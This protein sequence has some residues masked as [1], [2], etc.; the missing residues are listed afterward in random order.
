MV[1][2]S[3]RIG[4]PWAVEGGLSLPVAWMKARDAQGQGSNSGIGD[5]LTEVRWS[6]ARRPWRLGASVGAYWPLGEVGSQGLPAT[7][8]FST[9]TVDPAVGLRLSGPS[10]GDLGWLLSV[11]ARIVVGGKDNGRRLGSTI[12]TA[13]ELHR[14]FGSR[15]TG[16]VLLTHFRREPD[17]GQAMEDTGGSWIYLQPVLAVDL[18]V[19]PEHAIQLL[20]GARSPL[21]QDVQGIQLVESPSVTIGL[22][23]QSGL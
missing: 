14:E 13:A 4:L 20:F 16:Q 5:L 2:S 15:L 12:T 11:N 7:A 8:T 19:R 6:K 10:L 9:G 23:Y 22:S 17:R 21:I 1:L 3:F 18:L